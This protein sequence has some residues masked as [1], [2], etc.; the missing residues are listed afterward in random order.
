MSL[1]TILDTMASVLKVQLPEL[2]L[3]EMFAGSFDVDEMRRHSKTLPAAFVAWAGLRDGTWHLGK[4]VCR[5]L[6]VVRIAVKSRAEG[7]PVTQDRAHAIAR[8]LSRAIVVVAAAENWGDDEVVSNPLRVAAINPY[9][10]AADSIGLAL[11]AITWEQELELDGVPP[12]VELP[13]LT[14]IFADFKMAESTNPID[15]QD[16]IKTDV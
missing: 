5:G 9:S 4:F 16:D 8:L 12:A 7:Q 13:P 6:F 15:A 2:V 11:A 14:S 1:D 10:K 3:S